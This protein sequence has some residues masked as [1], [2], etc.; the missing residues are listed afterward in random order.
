MRANCSHLAAA[1][2]S[3]QYVTQVTET[4]NIIQCTIV[5]SNPLRGIL[6][7]P[8]RLLR[9][10]KHQPAFHYVQLNRN[11]NFVLLIFCQNNH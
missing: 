3:T 8:K 7:P 9:Y 1:T 11:R 6:G 5:T 4:I 10:M 2:A